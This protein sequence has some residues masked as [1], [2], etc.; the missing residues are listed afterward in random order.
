[1]G[2]I[3]I[4]ININSSLWIVFGFKIVCLVKCIK[5]IN[6]VKLVKRFHIFP[7][8]SVVLVG[9]KTGVG[10]KAGARNIYK[11]SIKGFNYFF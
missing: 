7:L 9:S 1:M 10:S 8:K 11:T 3:I 6:F 4:S 2:R 5:C